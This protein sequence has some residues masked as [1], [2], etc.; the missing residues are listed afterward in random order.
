MFA[1]NLIARWKRRQHAEY[2]ND[3]KP[4]E[5]PKLNKNLTERL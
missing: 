3:E 5:D 1:G 2:L 4:M